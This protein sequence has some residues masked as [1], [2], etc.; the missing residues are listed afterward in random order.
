[1]KS[2]VI[3][4]VAGLFIASGV[5]GSVLAGND[6][7]HTEQPKAQRIVNSFE[8]MAQARIAAQAAAERIDGHS[9][10]SVISDA[11]SR[12]VNPEYS[13]LSFKIAKAAVAEVDKRASS[14]ADNVSII[15]AIHDGQLSSC[16]A[17]RN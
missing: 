1:M 13:A 8:C 12:A 17:E 4:A 3:A 16:V 11:V 10:E 14:G 6:R 2:I 9:Q 15:K 5:A 7:P